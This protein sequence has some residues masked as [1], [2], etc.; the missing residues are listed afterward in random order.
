MPLRKNLLHKSEGLNHRKL[1][2]YKLKE[3]FT[4][5]FFR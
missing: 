5:F 3:D 2:I 4:F 1:E